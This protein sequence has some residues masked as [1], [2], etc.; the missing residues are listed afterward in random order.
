MESKNLKELISKM[1]LEEK[2]GLCSGKDFWN[3]KDVER[4][5]IPSVMVT[6]GP[7]GLRKQSEAAD[8]LGINESVPAVCYPAGCASAASFNEKT[9]EKL[10]AALGLEAKANDVSV[11]LGPGVNIKR[12]PLCGRNFEYYSEDPLLASTMGVGIVNG[13][14]SN[15]VGACVKHFLANNQENRRMSSNSE[16]DDRTLREIYLRAFEDII[17]KAKPWTIM[18]AYNR[19]NGEYAS[20][21]KKFLTDILRNEWGFDGYAMT[22]WG[23]MNERVKSL[24]AGLEL[25]MPASGP[26]NDS[27]IVK[28]VK[29]GEL[30]ES[31]LDE[32]CY[33]FLNILY[34]YYDNKDEN[35]TVDLAKHHE[36]AREIAEDSIVL[37]KNENN[38]LPLNENAKVAFIGKYAK[39]PRYQGGGSSHINAYKVSGAVDTITEIVPNAKVT[40]AQGFIDEKDETRQ[41][42][43]NEAVE[44]AKNAEIAV[45][46]VGLPDAFES[47]GYDRKHLRM[48][49]CQVELIKAV[50]KVQPNVVV[51]LHNGSPIEMPWICDVNAVVEA[52]LGGEAIGGAVV[53]VLY[54]KVN[55]SGRLPETFPLKLEHS[56]AYESYGLNTDVVEYKEGMFVGYRHYT[57]RNLDVLFSFGHGLS[58][59]TFEYSNLKVDK[60]NISN[61]DTVEV[62]VDVKNTGNVFGKEVVQLFVASTSTVVPKP[63]RELR[64]FTKIE[65]EPNETKTVKFE[66]NNRAFAYWSVE[67]NDWFVESGDYAIQICKDANTVILEETIAILTKQRIKVNYTQNSTLGDVKADESVSEIYENTMKPVIQK[68]V[69]MFTAAGGDVMNAEMIDTMME[70]M[71]L[72]QLQSFIPGLEENFVT[73]LVKELNK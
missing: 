20:E 55:P 41:E 6:D 57:K 38:I 7:H 21:N 45:L 72:R 52:Y 30:D 42:L 60:K 3:T 71:I 39:T 53:N 33:R 51:V 13:I 15:N 48:P 11:V 36:I 73:S 46:F 17:V 26:L 37:L 56:P 1:T 34:R 12:S 67:L 23:A 22:D 61:T 54:G 35:L 18:S 29:D 70:G 10:G 49:D 40:Y 24:K 5:G 28:A 4:L 14:Q 43:L 58:Y 8:H 65:L 68:M 19:I 44:V 59:T 64:S 27:L 25:E 66:L 16:V 2:A 63:V 69:E 31:V 62:T 47:E 50:K 9:L 32:A